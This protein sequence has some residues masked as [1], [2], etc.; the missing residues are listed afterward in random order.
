MKEIRQYFGERHRSLT[1]C[2]S[3]NY[4]QGN[5]KAFRLSV[6]RDVYKE[7]L[8]SGIQIIKSS[9]GRCKRE[10]VSVQ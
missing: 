9:D 2:V 4:I 1:W 10:V 6:R 5:Q 7:C 8:K 3:M